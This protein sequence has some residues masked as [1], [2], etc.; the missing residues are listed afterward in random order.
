VAPTDV[1]GASKLTGEWLL[2]LHLDRHQTPAGAVARLFNVYG[3]GETNPHVLPEILRH[4]R[5]G[6]RIPLGN[7]HPE[8]DYVFIDDAVLALVELL[9][10]KGLRRREIVKV[11]TGR[12]VSVERLVAELRRLTSRPLQIEIDAR[13][14]RNADRLRLEADTRHLSEL[15][16]H[17]GFKPI[18]QGLRATLGA[19]SLASRD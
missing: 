3:P 15:L 4:L 16:P 1:Y 8:R 17:V 13:K 2:W 18:G 10:L 9:F 6:H 7:V 5:R 19:E 14:L 12:A 11:G